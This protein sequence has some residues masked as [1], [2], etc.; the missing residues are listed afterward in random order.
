M[1]FVT[2]RNI[3]HVTHIGHLDGGMGMRQ[4]GVDGPG[5]AV[6]TNPE[7]W[8]A[9]RGLNGPEWVFSCPTAQWVNALDM[10]QEDRAEIEA[11][12]V[13]R[14]YMKPCTAWAIDWVDDMGEWRDGVFATLVEACKAAGIRVEDERAR[15][16][17]NDGQSC[18]I[19]HYRLEKRAM[20]RLGGWPDALNWFDAAMLLYTR[21]VIME[22][23]PFVVGIWWEEPESGQGRNGTAPY[24]VL[25]PERLGQFSVEDEEGEEMSFAEAFPEF[26]IPAAPEGDE[27]FANRKIARM[28]AEEARLV[29][30]GMEPREAARL[31]ALRHYPQA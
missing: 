8:R 2:A 9:L 11:W 24:G 17:Q 31:V 16:E 19:D 22:K 23:R 15:S 29:A 26:E 18:E 28:L 14:R 21:E 27:A 12:M 3:P 30:G 6:S 1:P 7:R 5:I 10:E 20:K 13:M 4:P 25:F